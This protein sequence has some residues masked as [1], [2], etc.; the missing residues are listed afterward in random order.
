MEM[1]QIRPEYVIF[2]DWCALMTSD[3]T[4][5]H[6]LAGNS[7][8]QGYREGIG[9]EAR[10]DKI[11]GFAQ[12][13]EKRV[14]LADYHN[15]CLRLIHRTSHST[16]VFSGRCQSGGYR[17]GRPGRFKNPWSTLL[18]KKDK[19]QLL[20]ADNKN[21]AV[22]TVDVMS[23]AVGT[24]VKSA[25]LTYIRPMTQDEKSGD[26]YVNAYHAIYRIKYTQRTVSLISGGVG[27]KYGYRDSMLLDSLFSWPYDLT[28]I[29]PSTLLVADD[30]RFRLVDMNSDKVTTLNVSDSLYSADSLLLTNNTLFVGQRKKIIKY[31]C[32]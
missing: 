9:G 15:D 32:E 8:L 30:D 26:L 23:Q 24:F 6:V 17:E 18:D 29:N 2:T 31:E 16:S 3:G 22:R 1:D 7:T 27:P 5:T 11:T 28:L 21:G 12:I 20:V 4:T 19:K 10:F 13:S 25:S 14:V